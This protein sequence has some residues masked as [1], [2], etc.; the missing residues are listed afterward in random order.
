MRKRTKTWVTVPLAAVLA[1]H[2]TACWSYVTPE[3]QK[4]IEAADCEEL[5]KEHRN[6]AAAEKKLAE[7]IRDTS[8]STAAT[9]AVGVATLAVFGLGFFSWD[10]QADA[11][12]NLAEL[13]AYREAIAAEAKKK[14]CK[15]Q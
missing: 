15:L 14:N 1:L 11:K 5:I 3:D 10:D 7:E 4:L 2:G 8:N 13:T 9:N 12:T 6:F